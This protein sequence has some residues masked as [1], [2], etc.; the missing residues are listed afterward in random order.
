MSTLFYKGRQLFAFVDDVIF[1]K[2]G[3]KF[4]PFNTFALRNAKIIYNFGFSEC[5]RVKS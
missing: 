3:S 5:N 2:L 4:L 1:P